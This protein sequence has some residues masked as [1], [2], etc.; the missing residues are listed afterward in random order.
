[1]FSVL[2]G[3]FLFCLGVSRAVE[4]RG[5]LIFHNTINAWR[6]LLSGGRR[7]CAFR[8]EQYEV[9]SSQI[10]SL[11]SV[12]HWVRQRQY[13]PFSRS[14]GWS[15]LVTARLQYVWHHAQIICS[16]SAAACREASHLCAA[17]L[18]TSAFCESHRSERVLAHSSL[19]RGSTSTKPNC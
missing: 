15:R 18:G 8:H 4:F 10:F 17:L 13:F 16:R 12:W 19:H 2:P 5:A 14:A 11:R 7:G 6:Y 3:L 9:R 1:M